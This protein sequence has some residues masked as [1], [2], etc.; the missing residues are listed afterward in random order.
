MFLDS[1]LTSSS[2]PS[3]AFSPNPPAS[4][5]AAQST[6]EKKVNAATQAIVSQ[7]VRKELE[8]SLAQ[9]EFPKPPPQDLYFLPNSNNAEFLMCLGLE[10]VVKCVHEHLTNKQQKQE[11]AKSA[12]Q[13]KDG[14]KQENTE[15]NVIEIKYEYPMCCVQ[16]K[17]DFTPVWRKDKNG[18]VLCEKCLKNIEIKQIKSEHN[19]KLKQVFLKVVKDK[20]MFEKQFLAEQQQLLLQQPS[21]PTS[22]APL[23]PNQSNMVIISNCSTLSFEIKAC[24]IQNSF[25]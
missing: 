7:R 18:A 11:K 12:E 15:P 3:S 6:N 16:C 1:E 5:S 19:A 4:Q 20:E 14:V 22:Q 23:R 13:D 10:E 24:F 17:T 8:K 2:S 21:Q 9:I 25:F